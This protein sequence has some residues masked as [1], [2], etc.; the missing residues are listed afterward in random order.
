M[1]WLDARAISSRWVLLVQLIPA[2]SAGFLLVQPISC[3]SQFRFFERPHG[4]LTTPT[5]F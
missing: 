2:V 5:G 1:N 3:F 4:V